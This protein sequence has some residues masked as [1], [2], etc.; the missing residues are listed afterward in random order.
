VSAAPAT[1]NSQ[2]NVGKGSNRPL[3]ITKLDMKNP[4]H[5][6]VYAQYRKTS[7]LA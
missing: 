5:R 2:S 7:G 4:E 6:K 3:D 1:T